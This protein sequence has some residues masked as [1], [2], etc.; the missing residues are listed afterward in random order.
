[1]N[2]PSEVETFL[3]EWRRCLDANQVQEAFWEGPQAYKELQRE[4]Y[5]IRVRLE[6]QDSRC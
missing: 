2:S 1:M 4:D 5:L 6:E 3:K